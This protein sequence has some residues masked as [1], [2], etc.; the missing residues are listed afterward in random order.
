MTDGSILEHSYGPS[1]TTE[2]GSP[3]LV[4]DHPLDSEIGD[5]CRIGRAAIP[6]LASDDTVRRVAARN[7]DSLYGI[8]RMSSGRREPLGFY[9]NLLLNEAGVEAVRDGRLNRA[10]P[11]DEHMVEHGVRPAAIYSWAVVAQ[12]L[13]EKTL[14][15]LAHRMGDLYAE[16]PIL[17]SAATDAGRKTIKRRGFATSDTGI[18]TYDRSQDAYRSF[19]RA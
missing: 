5:L 9:A 12:G 11:A 16:L 19:R 6:G 8:F 18:S 1:D 2:A 14:P 13:F 4:V 17:T 7:R 10:C 15:L 3:F